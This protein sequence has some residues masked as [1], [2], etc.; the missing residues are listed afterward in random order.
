MYAQFLERNI[1]QYTAIYNFSFSSLVN[2]IIQN[3]KR[4]NKQMFKLPPSSVS[5]ASAVSGI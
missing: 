4:K 3:F 2:K 1:V 5:S